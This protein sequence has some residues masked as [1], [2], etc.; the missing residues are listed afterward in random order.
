MS[1]TLS[2]RIHQDPPATQEVVEQSSTGD[3][4]HPDRF[5]NCETIELSS[6]SGFSGFQKIM[7]GQD[8]SGRSR[9][10]FLPPHLIHAGSIQKDL[11]GKLFE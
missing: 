9:E 4:R 3:F 5:G 7:M 2:L 6:D 10:A 11:A 8:G 1:N